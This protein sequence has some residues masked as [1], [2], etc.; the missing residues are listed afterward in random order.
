MPLV[1]PR[2]TSCAI[3]WA[4]R[5]CSPG[6]T[7]NRCVRRAFEGA[8]LIDGNAAKLYCLRQIDARLAASSQPATILDLGCGSGGAFVELLR[9]HPHARYVGVEPSGDA[10]AQAQSLLKDFDATIVQQAAYTFAGEPAQFVV[11]FSVLEHVYDRR[12]Y[13]ACARL[14]LAREGLFYINYDAGHFS[15]AAGWRDRVKTAIGRPLA[16]L[17]WERF[18]QA[19]VPEAEFRT[20]VEDAGLEIRDAK[21]FNSGLKTVHKHV[22]GGSREE[23]MNRWL[24]FE[25]FLNDTGMSYREDLASLFHTRNFIL[26]H[27]SGSP[28]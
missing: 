25:L 7:S 4:L 6:S 15:P 16:A 14:N 20:L 10:C 23:F 27:R 28:A 26:R 3:S 18:F 13:L 11:S 2:S 19:L 1:F 5:C 24:E 12:S 21:F 9:R 22:P 17:G 8:L